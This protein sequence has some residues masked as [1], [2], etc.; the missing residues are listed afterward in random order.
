MGG[1]AL[2]QTYMYEPEVQLCILPT[3]ERLVLNCMMKM[4]H[5]MLLWIAITFNGLMD[6]SHDGHLY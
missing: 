6:D 1:V 2:V 5:N 4:V 3:H